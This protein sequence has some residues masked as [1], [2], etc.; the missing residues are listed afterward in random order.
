MYKLSKEKIEQLAMEIISFLKKYGLQDS[1]CIYFNNKRWRIKSEYL[2]NGEFHD[3]EVI[4]DNMNPLDYFKYANDHH[5]LSMSFEGGL[6][7]V[8]NYTYGKRENQFLSIFEKYDLYYEFGNAWNLSAFPTN[9]LEYE[10]IEY[11]LYER[12]P[13]PET[14]YYWKEDMPEELKMIM[15]KWYQL[16]SDTGDIGGCVIGAYMEFVY[17]GIKYHMLP[18]SPYQGE[19]SWTPHIDAVKHMLKDIGA[20]E[21]YWNC[22]RLD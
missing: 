1:V 9:G 15:E 16:S 8:L 14:I 20:T 13:D 22:G 7:E 4:E 10:D 18:C 19:C 17:Q 21:I 12:E 5:I 11:T 3:E 6:Y 2:G